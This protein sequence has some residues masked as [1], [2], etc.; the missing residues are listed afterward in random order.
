VLP[1]LLPVY[2]LL[3]RLVDR[4]HVLYGISSSPDGRIVVRFH[5]ILYLK[6]LPFPSI[7]PASLLYLFRPLLP[8]CTIP[9]SVKAKASGLSPLQTFFVVEGAIAFFFTS[10]SNLLVRLLRIYRSPYVSCWPFR[11]SPFSIP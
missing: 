5:F 2:S 8:Y 3:V 10:F 1:C 4:V 6:K 11:P 9:S 7:P